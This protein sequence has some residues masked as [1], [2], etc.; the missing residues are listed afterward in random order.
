MSDTLSRKL[1]E[2]IGYIFETSQRSA[3]LEVLFGTY[4]RD[5]KSPFVE[6]LKRF[7]D[8]ERALILNMQNVGEIDT[9]VLGYMYDIFKK[10]GFF[11]FKNLFAEIVKT[12]LQSEY[13][14]NVE[15]R[16]FVIY[17]DDIVSK[18]LVDTLRKYTNGNFIAEKAETIRSAW[19][20][21]CSLVNEEAFAKLDDMRK[22]GEAG[23]SDLI[24]DFEIVKPRTKFSREARAK[25][26]VVVDFSEYTSVMKNVVSVML[27]KFNA[28]RIKP[29]K[30]YV[31]G[32][33]IFN[34]YL[35]LV[36]ILEK[37]TVFLNDISAVRE[38]ARNDF[39]SDI[40]NMSK[41]ELD[42]VNRF[43]S[44]VKKVDKGFAKM[45]QAGSYAGSY[46]KLFCDEDENRT[47]YLCFKSGIKDD[48]TRLEYPKDKKIFS[49]CKRIYSQSKE[50]RPED[51]AIF[52]SRLFKRAFGNAV[53]AN[54]TEILSVN[55]AYLDMMRTRREPPALKK[56]F[57]MKKGEFTR[58]NMDFR[59]KHSQAVRKSI[60]NRPSAII[61]TANPGAGKTY[62]PLRSFP[63][64]EKF[65]VYM[66][67]RNTLNESIAK[68]IMEESSIAK[69]PIVVSFS[70]D[71][72]NMRFDEENVDEEA[73]RFMEERLVPL[74]VS[75]TG[76]KKVSPF[77]VTFHFLRVSIKEKDEKLRRK[78]VETMER[79]TN[80]GK[81]SELVI[82]LDDDE[83]ETLQT[84]RRKKYVK[85]HTA[86]YEAKTDE[87]A[88][89]K[90]VRI[91]TEKSVYET[92]KKTYDALSGLKESGDP[93][94]NERKIFF[95]ATLQAYERGASYKKFNDVFNR[96]LAH[97]DTLFFD[98]ILG[99]SLN[100]QIVERLIK[101][102]DASTS[103]CFII[104]DANLKSADV[105]KRLHEEGGFYPRI[106]ITEAH[107][108]ED[109]KTSVIEWNGGKRVEVIE[110]SAFPADEVFIDMN[111]LFRISKKRD[112][113]GAVI[114]FITDKCLSLVK[115]KKRVF[116]YVQNKEMLY[117][118]ESFLTKEHSL[119]TL[120]I[121][122]DLKENKDK[123]QR[124]IDNGEYDVVLAT[125]SA[126]RGLSFKHVRDFI[127]LFQNFD[128]TS[129]LSEFSQVIYR[130]RGVLKNEK[131]EVIL[132][133]DEGEKRFHVIY[134]EEIT[135]KVLKKVEESGARSI[136]ALKRYV[137]TVS[138][139]FLTLHVFYLFS[140]YK[141][142]RK[143]IV[144]I[145]SS[146]NS[147]SFFEYIDHLVN[148]RKMFLAMLTDD[149]VKKKC[150]NKT[151]NF[152][153]KEPLCEVKDALFSLLREFNDIDDI[154]ITFLDD[155]LIGKRENAEYVN[156]VVYR[157]VRSNK[158]DVNYGN[159]HVSFMRKIRTK[160]NRI[161]D[162]FGENNYLESYFNETYGKNAYK[163]FIEAL[164][165]FSSIDDSVR[166][167]EYFEGYIASEAFILQH[168]YVNNKT[169][170]EKE[171]KLSV[172]DFLPENERDE[173]VEP[174]TFDLEAVSAEPVMMPALSFASHL[175]YAL[176]TLF[177]LGRDAIKT[178]ADLFEIP[179]E[180]PY[181]KNGFV[182]MFTE[183]PKI[184]TEDASSRSYVVGLLGE[185]L[186]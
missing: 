103:G 44:F 88:R 74:L 174:C 37:E 117:E 139:M 97:G 46:A 164:E 129:A 176:S 112:D 157:K 107:T 163:S 179:H 70:S 147:G 28:E 133:N 58:L 59:Q 8:A 18:T 153:V 11:Y 111:V 169:N 1:S 12:E 66:S 165:F 90:S 131:G 109:V 39:K 86:V 49:Y 6:E 102:L 160:A 144:P 45:V 40:L 42:E 24:F 48:K 178:S 125:S 35:A 96:M 186:F 7:K 113:Y 29:T 146:K 38:N 151:Q 175:R 89:K 82:F 166:M 10:D 118:I 13:I 108:D 149:K 9:R 106:V 98:E 71:Y 16:P 14:Q 27:D 25:V 81:R 15:M 55:H 162:L 79:E 26:A 152:S 171:I 104:A 36:S 121:T 31:N 119:E 77:D 137:E 172:E 4:I 73:T 52:V 60:E 69:K 161:R 95:T 64:P 184:P 3:F 154:A 57:H 83:L 170:G 148:V 56:S 21:L 67:S 68:E 135:K 155:S 105:I 84:F 30:D 110:A 34:K 158:H 138:K 141:G 185:Y 122:S 134:D 150:M 76:K 128:I 116:V 85:K 23:M 33:Y 99:T 5:K 177:L 53:F 182:Y 145:P 126:S 123:I 32:L 87:E 101:D 100:F 41:K 93:L 156:G 19:N 54:E 22:K 124:K 142:E 120:M 94:F 143:R 180:G 183:K 181:Y 127:V 17:A 130:G 115:E 61:L 159:S 140:N 92:F 51:T 72:L 167:K 173:I 80:G 91:K 2:I 62:T 43:F 168:G 20:R 114:D 78:I 132:N 65:F 75:D 63:G 136:Y 47:V 50:P